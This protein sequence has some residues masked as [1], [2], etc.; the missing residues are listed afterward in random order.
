MFI[1]ISNWNNCWRKLKRIRIITRRSLMR[2]NQKI[3]HLK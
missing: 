3:R 2:Q 1:S